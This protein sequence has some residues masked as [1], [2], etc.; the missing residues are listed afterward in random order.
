[1]MPMVMEVAATARRKAGQNAGTDSETSVPGKTAVIVSVAESMRITGGSSLG[2]E[3]KPKV[4]ASPALVNAGSVFESDS[5]KPAA[6]ANN[7]DADSCASQR[8]SK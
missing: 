1:M 5:V 6:P 7:L 2:T 3:M 8:Q 4:G